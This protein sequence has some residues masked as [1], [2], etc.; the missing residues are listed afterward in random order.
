M[1]RTKMIPLAAAVA[2]LAVT[3]GASAAQADPMKCSNEAKTCS[4]NC[5]KVARGPLNACLTNCGARASYCIKTGCWLD[6]VQRI[7]GLAKQ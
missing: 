3:A 7:C 2:L 4:S 5:K 6:G 1:T